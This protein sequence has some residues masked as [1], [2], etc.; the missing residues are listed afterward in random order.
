MTSDN[1]PPNTGSARGWLLHVG[2]GRTAAVGETELHEIV[3]E[4][5]LTEDVSAPAH[6]R[7]RLTWRG[8]TLPVADLAVVFGA[9]PDREPARWVTV[10]A[11]APEGDAQPEFAALRL[12]APPVP[13]RVSDDMACPLPET[14]LREYL[15]WSFLGLSCFRHGDRAVPVIDLAR[16]F[17]PRTQARLARFGSARER[18]VTEPTAY[19]EVTQ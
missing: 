18:S 9:D 16:L 15:I 1:T 13:V 2:E 10:A 8:R 14:S 19:T 6:T 17:S 12:D 7:F 5:Q 4:P 11:F 3:P